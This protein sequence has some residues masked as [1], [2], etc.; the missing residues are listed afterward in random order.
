LLVEV[1]A[2]WASPLARAVQTAMVALGPLPAAAAPIELKVNAR[3]R[4]ELSKLASSLGN[5]F[6]D[7]IRIRSLAK[8]HEVASI[9][10]DVAKL[11]SAVESV[12]VGAAETEG[13]WWSSN[14]ETEREF[15]SRTDDL[16]MQLQYS[17]HNLIALVG[18]SDTL[19]DMLGRHVQEDAK[20]LH[21]TLISQLTAAP[22]PPCTI[23]YA[24]LDFR[25]GARPIVDLASVD[26][27]LA[28]GQ[29]G[30]L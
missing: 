24:R 28:N 9:D 18:H 29:H 12:E 30:I 22:L 26:H 5:S 20:E 14:T 27:A 3:E 2:I 4:R 1:E 15:Q 7:H 25:R 23:V 13:Q 11:L 19:H 6:G 21:G 10:E 16:L 17:T 8:L